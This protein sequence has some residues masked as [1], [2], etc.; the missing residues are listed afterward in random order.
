VRWCG[1]PSPG[2]ICAT[3]RPLDDLD[4]VIEIFTDLANASEVTLN[5]TR[6]GVREDPWHP[7]T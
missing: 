1:F 3:R 2:L 7:N 6:L 4:K 5:L